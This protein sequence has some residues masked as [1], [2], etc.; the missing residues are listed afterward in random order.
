MAAFF[1]PSLFVRVRNA[2]SRP[3]GLHRTV[4]Y[5]FLAFYLY[6]G[7]RFY[8]YAQWAMGAS[9]DYV[10]KPASVEAFL[11]ISALLAAKR[12]LLTGEYDIVH[13]A[14]LTILLLA[15]ISSLLFRKGFCGY[16]CPIGTLSMLLDRLGKRLGLRRR[17]P[18]WLSLLLS[19]P[20]YLLLLFFV[21]LLLVQ[22]DIASIESFLRT[23]YNMVADSKMLL[24]FWHPSRTLLITLGV[25]VL[26]SM[27]FPAFWCRGFCP[28]GA[29][30]GLFSMLSPLAVRR[31][32]HRCTG[33]HRC[34]QA[35]PSRIPV[36]E[37]SR[38]SNP[39]CFGCTECLGACPVPGCLDLHFGYTSRAGVLPFWSAALGTLALLC[40]L[41]FWAVSS[42]NWTSQ[43]PATMMRELHS[44]IL[45]LEH[46]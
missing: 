17:M 9:L 19:L 5:V 14:G 13:P 7:L 24:F 32:A 37:K 39:E 31:K 8:A 46:P 30:L 43:I 26:G 44:N 2:V 25:L 12:L 18:G 28:Y 10:P 38:V 41:Y 36:H 34:S 42:D 21:N 23:P 45:Q 35:C 33:C 1:S 27:L 3:A 22:M 6:V 20:K 11:P 29:L 40:L 16:L 4:Q 15:V